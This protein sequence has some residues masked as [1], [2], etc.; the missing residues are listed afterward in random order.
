M[1]LAQKICKNKN[2]FHTHRRDR[3]RM[4]EAFVG[5]QTVAKATK[6]QAKMDERMA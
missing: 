1:G 5:G 6:S 4:V 3:N 2:F